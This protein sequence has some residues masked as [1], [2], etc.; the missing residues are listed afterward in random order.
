MCYYATTDYTCRDWKW[1][2]MK[3]RCP[4][5]YRIGEACGA[6]LVHHESVTKSD[7]VCKICQ[8]IQVKERRLR[9]NQ[10]KIARWMKEGDKFRGSIE[11]AERESAFL[12]EQ[13]ED[14]DSRRPSVL[15]KLIQPNSGFSA[16]QPLQPLPPPPPRPTLPI[17]VGYPASTQP[18]NT[19]DRL[20]IPETPRMGV[21]STWLAPSLSSSNTGI[22]QRQYIPPTQVYLPSKRSSP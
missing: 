8:E 13:I 18:Y 12:H 22:P 2:N 17:R 7:H 3:E 20:S 14:L 6:K 21:T 11:K 15:M 10:E 4:R 9:K 1:G 16:V 19:S 5:Q